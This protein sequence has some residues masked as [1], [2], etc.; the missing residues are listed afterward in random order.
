MGLGRSAG[1]TQQPGSNTYRVMTAVAYYAGLRPSEVVMLRV[2]SAVLPVGVGD[3]STS[4]RQTSRSM[5]PANPKP[6][7]APCRSHPY[8][9]T[10]CAKGSTPTTSRDPSGCCSEPAT[11][12]ERIELGPVMAPCTRIGRSETDARLRLPTRRRN[13]MAPRRHAPRRNRPA[14]RTQRRNTRLH[15]RGRPR[16]RRTHRQP[17][18]RH[19]P[20]TTSAERQATDARR[21]ADVTKCHPASVTFEFSPATVGGLPD[22]SVRHN[23]FRVSDLRRREPIVI[24]VS[25]GSVEFGRPSEQEFANLES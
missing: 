4:P 12:P 19:I 15:L 1:V 13:R 2:R 6:D 7:P 22:L 23:A 14:T 25:R 5:N 8:S 17:T 18:N 21:R 16:R 3:D 20:P 24:S 10:S 9:S 11:T